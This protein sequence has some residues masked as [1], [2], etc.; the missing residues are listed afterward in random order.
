MSIDVIK[1]VS[2]SLKSNVSAH[3]WSNLIDS[4]GILIHTNKDIFNLEISK[5]IIIIEKQ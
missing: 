3:I 5:K 1:K 2:D 4:F